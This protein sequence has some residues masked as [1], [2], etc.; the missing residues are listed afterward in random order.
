MALPLPFLHESRVPGGGGEIREMHGRMCCVYSCVK[1]KTEEMFWQEGL[2]TTTSIQKRCGAPASPTLSSVSTFS[3]APPPDSTELGLVFP[4]PSDAQEEAGSF[5]VNNQQRNAVGRCG[6]P[7]RQ[8]GEVM[9]PF[10]VL[11][12]VHVHIKFQ[13]ANRDDDNRRLSIQTPSYY[14]SLLSF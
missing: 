13:K 1:L 8:M 14:V 12:A 9:P 4:H 10:L 5:A 2:V 3:F 7:A 6:R 11:E